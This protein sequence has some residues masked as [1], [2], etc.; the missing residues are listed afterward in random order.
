MNTKMSI[1]FI[2]TRLQHFTNIYTMN[3]HCSVV[4]DGIFT[5]NDVKLNAQHYFMQM[6]QNLMFLKEK[7]EEFKN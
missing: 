5:S 6:C 1:F 4:K 2:C 3:F 7:K